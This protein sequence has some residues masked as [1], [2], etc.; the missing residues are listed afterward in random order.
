[1][2]FYK[3]TMVKMPTNCTKCTITICKL[4]C[5][6]D[7]D[8]IL[9]DYFDKRHPDCPLQAAEGKKPKSGAPKH[10]YGEYKNVLLTDEQLEKLKT[11]FPGDWEARVERLSEYMETKGAK[12]KNHYATIKSWARREKERAEAKRPEQGR[13]TSYD[14][15]ELENMSIFDDEKEESQHDSE[16]GNQD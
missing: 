4:P 11:E 5:G 16:N 14:I 8:G 6:R 12:Y 7:S 13:E 2:I 9:P 3:T 1:M 10:K 15:E